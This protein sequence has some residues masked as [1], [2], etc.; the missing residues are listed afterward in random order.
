MTRAE[1]DARCDKR[2]DEDG[3]VAIEMAS[4]GVGRLGFKCVSGHRVYEDAPE[5][6]YKSSFNP[7]IHRRA[8]TYYCGLPINKDER[9]RLHAGC[10]LSTRR[11]N[12]CCARCG[13][14]FDGE[15]A[16]N[17]K[18]HLACAEIVQGR[19][20]PEAQRQCGER[21]GAPVTLK[22]PPI[23]AAHL[24]ANPSLAKTLS[25]RDAW[26]LLKRRQ[27]RTLALV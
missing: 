27:V 20:P 4:Y 19:W 21:G 7:E 23:G 12:G 1:H 15:V 8:C 9:G 18:Y 6:A 14:A 26:P 3:H 2:L 25:D 17:R 24:D 22:P 13:Q 11:S 5:L 16:P 10:R